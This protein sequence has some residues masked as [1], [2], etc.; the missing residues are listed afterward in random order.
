MTNATI[1]LFIRGQIDKQFLDGLLSLLKNEGEVQFHARGH[2]RE[3]ERSNAARINPDFDTS[4]PS[5][6]SGFWK[7]FGDSKVLEDEGKPF[8]L[9]RATRSAGFEVFLCGDLGIRF[10]I[11]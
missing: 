4:T 7:W 5:S 8:T 6:S 1:D 11:I 9:F 3:S 10:G 2:G